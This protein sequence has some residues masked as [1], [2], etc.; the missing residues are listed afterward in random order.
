[1]INNEILRFE[2][3]IKDESMPL[4]SNNKSAK[5]E[6]LMDASVADEKIGASQSGLSIANGK[7]T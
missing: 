6:S 4:G 2:N 3:G 1:M 5:N 7:M